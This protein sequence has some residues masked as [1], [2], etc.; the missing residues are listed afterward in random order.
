MD[1]VQYTATKENIRLYV[2]AVEDLSDMRYLAEAGDFDASNKTWTKRA[3]TEAYESANPY[4]EFGEEAPIAEGKIT[5]FRAE[6][7]NEVGLAEYGYSGGVVYDG[8]S[9]SVGIVRGF[10]D[11]SKVRFDWDYVTAAS[12]IDHFSVAFVKKEA[13]PTSASWQN[14]GR[15]AYYELS[16]SNLADGTYRLYVKAYAKSGRV[17]ETWGISEPVAIDRTP[18]AMTKALFP[19]YAS[20]SAAVYAEAV[21]DESGITE[22][23]YAVGTMSDPYAYTGKWLTAST[24]GVLDKVVAFASLQGIVPDGSLLY[25]RVKARNGVGNW[26]G[27][28]SSEAILIDQTPPTRPVVAVPRYTRSATSV[29]GITFS[30][31]DEESGFTAF[32]I[33]VEPVD[34]GTTQWRTFPAELAPGSLSMAAFEAD[35]LILGEAATYSILVSVKNGAGDWSAT[36]K[37][38]PVT[39]DTI[40][41]VIHFEAEAGEVAFNDPPRAIAYSLSEAATVSL[42]MTRTDGSV[43]Q[44]DMSLS[45]GTY[46]FAFVDAVPGT[47]W[48]DAE[49][50]DLAGNQ[51]NMGAARNRQRIR[52]NMAPVITFEASFTTPGKPHALTATVIDP[53]GDT[54]LTYLWEFGDGTGT[55]TAEPGAMIHRYY[56]SEPHAQRSEYPVTL[57]VADA[58]GKSTT[59]TA[60]AIVENTRSGPLYT[61][62]YWIGPWTLNGDVTVGEG[63]TLTVTPASVITVG[64]ES[65]ED[66]PK[67][68]IVQGT[69]SASDTRFDTRMPGA[70]WKGILLSGHADLSRSTISSAERGLAVLSGAEAALNGATFTNNHIGLHVHGASVMVDGCRFKGNDRYG[71]K[72]D[73]GAL[74]GV[75]DSRFGANAYDYYDEEITVLD[76]EGVNGLSGN[77]GNQHE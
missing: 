40:A 27:A 52:V 62:E 66:F 74:I 70:Y 18:P 75:R 22:W 8:R 1:D 46:T 54:P 53:D 24:S 2:D 42:T 17:S 64:G 68:L 15:D 45:A 51:G 61:D 21:D 38:G 23:Q 60:K 37:V 6:V 63:I 3:G 71:I 31:I 4:F 55:G 56:H 20:A 13:N 5:M 65:M 28:K 36:E 73:A 33:G 67:A 50:I 10:V 76:V 16:L 44:E 32:R 34:G 47:Y 69:L 12:P 72:E 77:S 59:A 26:T 19:A 30:A 48:L 9:P 49:I 57:T 39:V 29:E 7:R 14:V 11:A 43:Y 35:G 58:L 25:V 41:P